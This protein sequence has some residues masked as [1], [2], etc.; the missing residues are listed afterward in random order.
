[1][2]QLFVSEGRCQFCHST[3]RDVEHLVA[4]DSGLI[5]NECV[6]ACVALLQQGEAPN[7]ADQ[8]PDRFVFDRLTR[9]AARV[10][11]DHTSP[12][13]QRGPTEPRRPSSRNC[14]GGSLNAVSRRTGMG[15]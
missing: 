5:C 13:L 9:Q 1:M 2:S 14:S 7:T 3:A 10:Q 8:R 12:K 15:R 6:A 11:A 4:G